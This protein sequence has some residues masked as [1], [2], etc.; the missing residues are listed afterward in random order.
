M[1]VFGKII[2][3][4]KILRNVLLVFAQH[5]T[6]HKACMLTGL[7]ESPS[8]RTP[9]PVVPKVAPESTGEFWSHPGPQILSRPKDSELL[10]HM[11]KC[12]HKTPHRELSLGTAEISLA[13][14]AH[15]SHLGPALLGSWP[16][17]FPSQS[18]FHSTARLSSL[19]PI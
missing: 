16:Q 6:A 19:K 12:N 4:Q 10:R 3:T 1:V 8:W 13:T 15:V 2:F 11:V 5:F 14:A 7:L 18:P 9:K 17:F